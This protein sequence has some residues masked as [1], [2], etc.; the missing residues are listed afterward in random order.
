MGFQQR[1]HSNAGRQI[2]PFYLKNRC[3]YGERCINSHCLPENK[4]QISKSIPCKFHLQ[5]FCYNGVKCIFSHSI[6]ANLSHDYCGKSKGFADSKYLNSQPKRYTRCSTRI[7]TNIVNKYTSEAASPSSSH[8]SFRQT[9]EAM[10][11]K[12]PRY[13]EWGY[14]TS[15]VYSSY[16]QLNKEEISIYRSS[17]NFIPGTI[18]LSSPPVDLC[19]S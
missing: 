11:M 16:D 2:C 9:E 1:G 5:G 17:G 18:P 14:E 19:T 6:N 8:F 4:F 10:K 15:D 7:D 13:Q 12:T 3:E